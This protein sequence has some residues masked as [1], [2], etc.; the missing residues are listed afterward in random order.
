MGEMYHMQVI[1]P[2]TLSQAK[3]EEIYNAIKAGGTTIRSYT[4]SLGVTG[5]FQL[6]LNVHTKKGEPCPICGNLI[7]KTRV[8]GRGTYLCEVCQK[9]KN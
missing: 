1:I 3:K 9:I 2:S 4:S 8:A 6:Q 5:L 7:T